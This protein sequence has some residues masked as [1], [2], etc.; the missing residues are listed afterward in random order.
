M[1]K[2]VLKII[3]VIAIVS[4]A[5]WNVRINEAKIIFTNFF[6][7]E[8]LATT[9]TACLGEVDHNTGVCMKNA[10]EEIGSSCIKLL[11]DES[12]NCYK[13]VHTSFQ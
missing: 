11:A 3:V 5:I 10:E 2:K 8:A 9:E 4:L 7:L 6:G 1:R 13:T 12:K